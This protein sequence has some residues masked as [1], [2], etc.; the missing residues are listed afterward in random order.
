MSFEPAVDMLAAC[1]LLLANLAFV[2]YTITWILPQQGVPT[3]VAVLAGVFAIALMS[4]YPWH[5]A[6]GG[7]EWTSCILDRYPKQME[8]FSGYVFVPTTWVMAAEMFGA[9]LLNRRIITGTEFGV[10]FG[11]CVLGILVLT[12]LLQEVHIPY[13]STQR[14]VL[15]CPEPAQ[16]SWL[17]GIVEALDTSL[18]AQRVLKAAG[19]WQ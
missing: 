3:C 18:L 9:T 8:G 6:L 14:L 12:V 1:G 16:G 7:E 5:L 10:V 4:V 2:Y 19:V 17:R 13:V 15:P 11:G